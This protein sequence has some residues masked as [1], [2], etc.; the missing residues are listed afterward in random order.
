LFSQA[1]PRNDLPAV[2][3]FSLRIQLQQTQGL[4][5]AWRIAQLRAG[6]TNSLLIDWEV[7]V[8]NTEAWVL[9]ENRNSS[10]E[11]GSHNGNGSHAGKIDL[12]L[13]MFS[14]PDL[15][16]YEVLAEPVVGCWEGNMSHAVTRRPVDICK[17][18]RENS[19]VIGNAGVVRVLKPG[20]G[21][22]LVKEGDL[23]L[24]FC[25]GS[26]DEF[27]Y[28]KK[29]YGYDAEGTVGLLAKK[30][31]LHE[32][33]LIRIPQDS[34]YSLQR[35]AAFSLRYITAWANWKVAYGVWKLHAGETSYSPSVWGWGG[36]VTLGE[37]LLAQAAGCSVYMMASSQERLSLIRQCGIQA[38]DRTAFPQLS[39]CPERYRAEEEYKRQY[40]E[41]EN[42]FL[43]F[44]AQQTNCRGVSIFVDFIGRPVFRVSLKSLSRP[45]VITT[46]GW[47]EGMDLAVVRALECMNWHTHVHTHYARY[48]EGIE[49][50]DYAEK[51]GWLPRVEDHMFGWEEIPTLAHEHSSGK[52]TSFFPLY[53]VNAA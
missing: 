5:S 19:V 47:K 12:R 32:R 48:A 28:P 45:G 21:V 14:L 15:K 2:S 31:K 39:F 4:L 49:A 38:V 53:K 11:N 33:Q 51:H 43:N 30:T 50:V 29:I 3:P 24:V 42:A 34:R 20:P 23:C 25:N 9:H 41:S 6:P 16:E 27:G 44:V 36:G 8:I 1:S 22:T 10:N 52:L 46:A 40:Q 37:L 13:E 18:R 26:W 17:L 7:T 35:W